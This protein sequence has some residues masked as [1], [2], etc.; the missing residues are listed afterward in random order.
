MGLS[1]NAYFSL[2]Y[3]VVYFRSLVFTAVTI[4]SRAVHL[5]APLL[6][7]LISAYLPGY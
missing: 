4:V 2:F 7:R 3:V 5:N 1:V 6:N